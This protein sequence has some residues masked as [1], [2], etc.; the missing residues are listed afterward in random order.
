MDPFIGEIKMLG[1]NYAP[2]GYAFCNGQ[3]IPIQQN[4]ALFSIIGTTYGGNGS[5]NFAL[6]NLQGRSPLA[7]GSGPG[8]TP[9]AIGESSGAASVTL[10]PANLPMHNH[11]LEGTTT[12]AATPP[13]APAGAVWGTGVSSGG[14]APTVTKLYATTLSAPVT[15]AQDLAPAGGSQPHNNES[16]FLTI[17]FVIATE[18]IFPQRP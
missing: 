2:V 17:N 13:V 16:P 14:K 8:L 18:G 1:C 15:M 7:W 10:T 6:P 9:R 11:V 5:S 4:P 3:L 12:V